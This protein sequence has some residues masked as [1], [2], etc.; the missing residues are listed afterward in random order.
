MIK[1]DIEQFRS[2][3]EVQIKDIITDLVHILYI[4]WW[5]SDDDSER[6]NSKKHKYSKRE[7]LIQI[8]SYLNTEQ[9][10]FSDNSILEIAEGISREEQNERR[11]LWWESS[12][13]ETSSVASP[14]RTL[15]E[16]L[17]TWKVLEKLGV[18][19]LDYYLPKHD[20]EYQPG[21]LA[22]TDWYV[23]QIFVWRSLLR[24]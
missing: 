23:F 9:N 3:L 11:R 4:D 6:E 14:Q 19:V 13:I 16:K 21:L 20:L 5:F 12:I 15:R 22:E 2:E 10:S 8:R 7:F 17:L 18:F 24:F 1:Q